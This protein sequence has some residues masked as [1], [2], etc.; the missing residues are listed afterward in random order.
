MSTQEVLPGFFFQRNWIP[1]ELE[2]KVT[3]KNWV[4]S[5]EKQTAHI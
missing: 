3:L 4:F 1:L 2:S 5:E